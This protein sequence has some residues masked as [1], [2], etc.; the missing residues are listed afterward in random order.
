MTDH[1]CNS[2]F[3]GKF[4]IIVVFVTNISANVHVCVHGHKV[5]MWAHVHFNKRAMHIGNN[6]I[7]PTYAFPFHVSQSDI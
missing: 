4:N 6:A 7:Q 1:W 5:D 2:T 3:I